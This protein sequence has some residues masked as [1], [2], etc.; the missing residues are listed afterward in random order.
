MSD[1]RTHCTD[2]GKE[3]LLWL[4]D[5]NTGHGEFFCKDLCEDDEYPEEDEDPQW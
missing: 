3:R 4:E 2:C 5:P 1:P